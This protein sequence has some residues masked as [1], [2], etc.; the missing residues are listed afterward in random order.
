M[1]K[2]K[3]H[4]NKKSGFKTPDNYFD[5][6]SVKLPNSAEENVRS[7]VKNSGF[8]TPKNYF[9]DFTVTLP[10]SSQ[11]KG[12]VI[13]LFKKENILKF[14]AAAAILVFIFN[15]VNFSSPEITTEE[16][17]DQVSIENYI[18]NNEIDFDSQELYF[19]F[20]NNSENI[21]QELEHLDRSAILEYLTENTEVTSLLND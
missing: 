12:K 10:H 1:K 6:F 7:K 5:N 9:N 21:Q 13:H 20:D 18:D 17:L 4:I 11:G 8:S 3:I 16:S 2:K 15:I 14:V 19:S